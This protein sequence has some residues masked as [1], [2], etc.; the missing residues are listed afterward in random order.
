MVAARTRTI[1]D[2][3][4]PSP[5]TPINWSKVKPLI[6]PWALVLLLAS[7]AVLGWQTLS[8]RAGGLPQVPQ[9]PSPNRPAPVLPPPPSTTPIAQPSNRD[10]SMTEMRERLARLEGYL[11]KKRSGQEFVRRE[12]RWLMSERYLSDFSMR[13]SSGL[14]LH[15]PEVNIHSIELSDATLGESRTV[16]M[17]IFGEEDA[18]VRH[19]FSEKT[20][21]TEEVGVQFLMESPR[22]AML[23]VFRAPLGAEFSGRPVTSPDDCDG[24]PDGESSGRIASYFRSLYD[25]DAPNLCRFIRASD[26]LPQV[27]LNPFEGV[28]AIWQRR[29]ETSS[30]TNGGVIRAYWFDWD[31]YIRET[32]SDRPR[33]RSKEQEEAAR[34]AVVVMNDGSATSYGGSTYATIFLLHATRLGFQEPSTVEDRDFFWI[35]RATQDIVQSLVVQQSCWYE[36]AY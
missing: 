2:H 33:R 29:T 4:M 16:S 19:G 27:T 23:R 13:M 5:L 32:K 26:A 17:D 28:G 34:S 31:A 36:C 35:D 10:P 18:E 25:L 6:L 14:R 3:R 7:N 20:P 22:S 8:R 11:P 1:E 12:L 9:Q 21:I 24:R 15:F 30:N